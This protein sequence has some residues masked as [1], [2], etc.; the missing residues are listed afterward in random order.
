M[1]I[2]PRYGGKEAT[3]EQRQALSERVAAWN[4][5]QGRKLRPVAEQLSQRYI[6]GELS[7]TEINAQL[8]RYY[9]TGQRN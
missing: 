2:N 7:L 5:T 1:E 6:A 3:C 9:S 8:D 4:A